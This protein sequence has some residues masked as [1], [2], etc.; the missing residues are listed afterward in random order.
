[1]NW[2]IKINEKDKYAEVDTSG[3]ADKVGS[4]NMV[5]DIMTVLSQKKIKRILI[6]HRNIESVS[7]DAL[8]VYDRPKEFE[9]IGIFPGIKVAEVVKPEH[10]E[11]F[12][13][14]ETVFRNRGYQFTVFL[15]Y[16]SAIEWLLES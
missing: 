4:L 7:G 5:K 15:E 14:L 2:T 3:D 1:M 6:D 16:E 10:E 12:C 9:K 13:F 8:D 11:F